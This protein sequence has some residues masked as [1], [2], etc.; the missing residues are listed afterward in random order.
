MLLLVHTP[1]RI[2]RE[3]SLP[4][5]VESAPSRSIAATVS[6]DSADDDSL[7]T[8]GLQYRFEIRVAEGVVRILF[9]DG[10]VSDCSLDVGNELPVLGAF[11]DGGINVPFPDQLIRR[12]RN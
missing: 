1:T 11:L 9:D 2:T 3:P 4:A 8:S 10:R 12:V 7:D 5:S 6:H